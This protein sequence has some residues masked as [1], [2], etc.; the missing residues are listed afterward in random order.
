M[1]I[2]AI[3]SNYIPKME[4][5]AWSGTRVFG[6]WNFQKFKSKTVSGKSGCNSEL[7]A[8]LSVLK[9]SFVE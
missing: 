8:M 1:L 9:S 7:L 6:N 5:T 4:Q 2:K 3:F